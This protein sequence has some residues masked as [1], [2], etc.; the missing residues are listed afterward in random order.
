M[1][2]Y[3]LLDA[4][5]NGCM[6]ANALFIPLLK[7]ASLYDGLKK[8]SF[9]NRKIYPH[10]RFLKPFHVMNLFFLTSLLQWNIHTRG[11]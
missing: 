10:M 9:S 6:L 8:L 5:F 1:Q 7:V 4:L 2:K 3:R 11:Q